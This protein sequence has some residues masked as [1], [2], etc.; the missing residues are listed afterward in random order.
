VVQAKRNGA[1]RHS[2]LRRFNETQKFGGEKLQG[3]ARAAN[4]IAQHGNVGTVGADASRVNGQTEPFGLI[5]V[6]AG[7][8]KL[9]QAETLCGEHTIQARR[10]YGTGGAMPLPWP[11]RQFI[12]LLPIAFVPSGHSFLAARPV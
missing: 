6:D 10:I 9:R 3:L 7:V 1:Q 4:K 5:K 11:P 8:I 2:R 12:E